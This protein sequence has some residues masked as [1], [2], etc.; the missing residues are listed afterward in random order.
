MPADS[1]IQVQH[2]LD[3]LRL[4]PQSMV[5]LPVMHRLAAAESSKHQSKCNI[6]KQCPI[7]G[8]RYV[9][10]SHCRLQVHISAPSSASDAGHVPKFHMKACH[11]PKYI[12][13]SGLINL[14][15]CFRYRCLRC[16]NFDMCQNCF[17]SGRK[18]KGHKLTH[19]MQEYCTAVSDL[20]RYLKCCQSTTG[21]IYCLTII[22]L[23][24]LIER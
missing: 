22:W 18:A 5:W 6:C 7:V 1:L 11:V 13:L 24:G 14:M 12:F 19:P 16:F 10:M 20:V 4:E 3:W 17:F 2:L 8:F 9:S 15:F 21:N 23:H